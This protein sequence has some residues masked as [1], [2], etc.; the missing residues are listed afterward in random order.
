MKLAHFLWLIIICSSG[1]LSN[2]S[3][4]NIPHITLKLSEIA[5]MLSLVGYIREDFYNA[6]HYEVKNAIQKFQ[7]DNGFRVT[8]GLNKTTWNQLR[9]DYNNQNKHKPYLTKTIQQQPKQKSKQNAFFIE[10]ID[11]KN[12]TDISILY[13]MTDKISTS[14][15]GSYL[16]LKKR[17]F[18]WYN[19]EETGEDNTTWWCIPTK[20]KCYS[21]VLSSHWGGKLKTNNTV[22]AVPSQLHLTQSKTPEVE[23]IKSQCD[24]KTIKNPRVSFKG[25]EIS[26]IQDKIETYYY[27]KMEIQF[28]N[29]KELN[30]GLNQYEPYSQ[31]ITNKEHEFI[32][33]RNV[34]K[35]LGLGANILIHADKLLII[36]LKNAPLMKAGLKSPAFLKKINFKSVSLKD[37]SSYSYLVDLKKSTSID[38]EVYTDDSFTYT[39]HYAVKIDYYNNHPIEHFINKNNYVI[40]IYQIKPGMTQNIKTLLTEAL[41]LKKKVIF[42][43]RYCP[44]GDLYETIDLVSLFIDEEIDV[45]TLKNKKGKH[46]LTSINGKLFNQQNIEIWIS[47]YTAS[48]AEIFTRLLRAFYPNTTI[49]GVKSVGKCL[50]QKTLKMKKG[51][52]KLTTDEILIQNKSCNKLPIEPDFYISSEKIFNTFL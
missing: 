3:E 14:K 43:L 35:Q 33:K 7:E 11:C 50:A 5:G 12:K 31:F 23:Y 51:F 10:K 24:I 30:I 34:F 6:T 39:R 42:D 4:D 22:F 1:C 9:S 32:K 20:M 40:R 49:K 37:F 36:P 44:G 2:T 25:A 21:D 48:S 41:K 17:F 26:K 38:I 28:N 13:W 45:L 16:K 18:L 15:Q 29:S 19:G 27:K 8:G 47:Q 52:L 46:H